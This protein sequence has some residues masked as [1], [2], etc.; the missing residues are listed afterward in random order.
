MYVFNSKVTKLSWHVLY[1]L[2]LKIFTHYRM[3]Q[4]FFK[5]KKKKKKKKKFACSYV[6]VS[7]VSLKLTT[8]NWTN[9]VLINFFFYQKNSFLKW[10]ES[11]VDSGWRAKKGLGDEST[12]FASC[13][14]V[15]VQVRLGANFDPF[16]YVYQLQNHN[17]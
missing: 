3:P 10:F 5:K 16:C 8:N 14:K 6:K 4:P 11:W 13:Q 9:I 15:W 17:L 2:Y 7:I 1:Y 12:H